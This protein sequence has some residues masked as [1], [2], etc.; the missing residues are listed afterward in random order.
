VFVGFQNSSSVNVRNA[1]PGNGVVVK[2]LHSASYKLTVVNCVRGRLVKEQLLPT[3]PR[4]LAIGLVHA[5]PTI[6]NSATKPIQCGVH[7]ANIDVTD[8]LGRKSGRSNRV[9]T[10]SSTIG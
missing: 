8:E 2:S 7:I 6:L 5:I 10:L 3:H 4:V 1:R 9:N